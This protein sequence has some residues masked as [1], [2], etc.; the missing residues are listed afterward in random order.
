MATWT[1]FDREAPELAELG[2]SLL[3]RTG[4]GLALL[5]TVRG[6]SLPPR[7]NPVNLEIVD[8]RLLTFVHDDSA[9]ARDLLEDGRYAIH[10]HQDPQVPHEFGARGRATLVTESDDRARAASV[11]PFKTNETY[12]LFELDIEHVL[13]GVRATAD[14]W[15]P[16]YRTWKAQ[17]AE[18][19]A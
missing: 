14:D 6:R 1:Q 19:V 11:W 16:V 7:I 3:Y 8:G 15:P 13:V 2:R 17:A 9:K 12:L 4:E 5:A 10:A 18:P